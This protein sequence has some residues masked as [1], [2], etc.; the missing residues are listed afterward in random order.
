MKS[1]FTIASALLLCGSF[2][3]AQE[4]QRSRQ[5]IEPRGGESARGA[6]NSRPGTPGSAALE[7]AGVRLGQSLPDIVVFDAKG[8]KFR[9]ADIKKKHTVIVFGCL[10]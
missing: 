9:V 8:G 4:S 7:R 1:V 6:G 5:R 2:S 10:T 3:L